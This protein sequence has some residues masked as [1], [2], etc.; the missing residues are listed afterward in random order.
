MTFLPIVERELRV[1]ARRW[2]T[3][4]LRVIAAGVALVIGGGMLL[5]TLVPFAG[6]MQS[7]GVMFGTLTWMSLAAA[8]SAGLFFTSDCLSEE[9]R[10]GTL[11]FLFLTDLRG[12]DVVLGKLLA[13]SLRSVFPL[14]AIFPILALTQLLGGVEVGQFWRALLAIGNATFFSLAVGMFVSTISRHALKALAGT[15]LLLVMLV[16]FGPMVDNLAG[17]ANG[18]FE[19]RLSLV[20]PGF[21]FVAADYGRNFWPAL[22]LNQ[23]VAWSLLGLT[24][25]LVRRTWQEK[26]RPA[27]VRTSIVPSAGGFQRNRAARAKLLEKNPVMWL[28]ARERGQM[29]AIWLVVLVMVT[30]FVLLLSADSSE[31]WW[32]G[33]TMVGKCLWLALYLWV[34]A[35]A[36]QLFADTRRSGMVELLMASPLSSRET[37]QGAWRGLVRLFAL[38]VLVLVCLQLFS[39]LAT[40][41]SNR[42]FGYTESG[43]QLIVSAM[44]VLV[45]VP[46]NLIALAWFGLWMGLTSK[47][48][49]TATLKTI[50]F[51]QIIPWFVISFGSM[52]AIPLLMFATGWAASSSAP[53]TTFVN[54][55]MPLLLIGLPS[56]LT[57]AKDLFLWWLAR[58]KLYGSFR[59]L[60]VRSVVPI[61]AV[62]VPPVLASAR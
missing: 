4:W 36:C 24:C 47:N 29:W 19:P 52:M 2:S 23:V 17:F 13:T 55:W 49:L 37:V 41:T 48:T 1:A 32:F 26:P 28:V 39:Q 62:C 6:P 57:L 11:G 46:M 43:W 20:S 25:L 14:L 56:V 10:E 44:A 53:S 50:L 33:W 31:G 42:G 38:P 45:V 16:G 30:S 34:A 60:A 59:Q 61:R 58:K 35:R 8:L 12:F 15:L 21:V 9:K 54:I 51:V 3:Y 18:R 40:N 22:L 7:G 27:T 5:L